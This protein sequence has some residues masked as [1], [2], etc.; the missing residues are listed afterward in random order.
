MKLKCPGCSKVLQV[1]AA[2]S[3]KM[4]ACPCGTKLRVPAEPAVPA[5][6]SAPS[7]SGQSP[8]SGA[9][10]PAAPARSAQSGSVSRSAPTNPMAAPAR[11]TAA[12]PA[13]DDLFDELSEADLQ[14]LAAVK[15][16]RREQANPYA[17]SKVLEQYVD[18]DDEEAQKYLGPRR[19]YKI[20]GLGRRFGGAVIDWVFASV[21]AIIGF[22]VAIA[23][24]AM[25]WTS[26]EWTIFSI[27]FWIFFLIS[28]IS[29]WIQ[30]FLISRRGQTLGKICV[31]TVI[32]DFITGQTVGFEQGVGK[33]WIGFNVACGIPFVGAFVYLANPF[34]VFGSDRQAI[35]DRIAGTTVALN[36]FR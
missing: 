2:A 15:T 17:S 36:Q 26:P 6:A 1:P 14:P 23:I 24:I 25:E 11:R 33:R 4:V 21:F 31:G 30:W 10:R 16:V 9:A 13:G 20:A 7:R 27:N 22:A 8:R 34:F 3:G 28:C 32:V 19:R 12:P 29:S 35:H 18:P 5:A